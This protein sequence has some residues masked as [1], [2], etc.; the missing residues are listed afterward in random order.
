M[1]RER[2]ENITVYS[3]VSMLVFGCVLTTIAFFIAPV[4][5]IHDSVLWVLGQCFIYAGGALGIANYARSAA[6]H[7]VD[8][9]FDEF[10]RRHHHHRHR[11]AGDDGEGE[12]LE[13]EDYTQ[14][15][16]PIDDGEN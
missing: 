14:Y 11:I 12:G 15:D 6:R 4:G 7:E 1:T 5:E 9:R 13:E 2:K 16:K 10:E 3:A 8:E